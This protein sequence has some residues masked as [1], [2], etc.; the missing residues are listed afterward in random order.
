MDFEIIDVAETCR[1]PIPDTY[2]FKFLKQALLINEENVEVVFYVLGAALCV[3][4]L[5]FQV[6]VYV[7]GDF[8][9]G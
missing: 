8:N 3:M 7:Y 9:K 2:I 6:I 4:I 5:R 1:I